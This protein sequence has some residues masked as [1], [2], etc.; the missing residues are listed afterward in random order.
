M[1][2][3]VDSQFA[4]ML[5]KLIEKCIGGRAIYHQNSMTLKNQRA[6]RPAR[7]KYLLTPYSDAY[8]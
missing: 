1:I 3:R 6:F 2:S 8:K 7:N 5:E 4:S